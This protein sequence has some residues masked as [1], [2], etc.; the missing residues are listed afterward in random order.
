MKKFLFDRQFMRTVLVIALPLMFQQL[1]S[2]SVNLVDNLM[3]GSL[4][5]IAIGSVATVNRYYQIGAFAING[6]TAAG[7]V[8]VAQ[9]YGAQAKDKMKE[10]FRVMLISSFLIMLLFFVVALRYPRAIMGYFTKDE[11]IISSGL[12]Y[13]AIAGWSLIPTGL[14]LCIYSAMRAVGEM[15]I[16]LRISISSVIV[17]G[18]LNYCLIF[19]R[20]GFPQMGLAGAALATVIARFLELTISLFALK[21]RD[22]PFKSKVQ[23]LFRI[24]NDLAVKILVKAAPLMLNEILWSFGM[25]TLFKFYST[26]GSEIMSGYSISGTIGDLFFSLFGG[27]AA[28]S[29]VLIST[30][31]GA[32]ELEKAKENAYRLIG[33][34]VLLSLV[35]AVMMFGAS[36]LVPILYRNT[37]LPTQNAAMTFLRVQ[38]CMFWIYMATTQCYFILRCGGDMKHTLIMDSGF[39]WGVNIP[40]IAFFT[41]FTGI[42]YLFLYMIGQMTDLVKLAFAMHLVKKEHWLVNLTLNHDELI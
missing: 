24:S 27:M 39:M 35:F 21:K 7:A 8:F 30:P 28:A 22:F 33:F 31:L 14:V 32:N 3:V 25:A 2:V 15:H 37:T 1:I 5:D 18:I 42:N 36:Y 16:P 19:G 34:S 26:R 12:Q 9:Y 23:H 38:S 40:I 11:A 20:F 29:T 17:N 41:Y 10:S 6:L 13:L 4:G